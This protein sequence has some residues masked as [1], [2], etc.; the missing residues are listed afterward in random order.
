MF[1]WGFGPIVQDLPQ[2]AESRLKGR[3]LELSGGTAVKLLGTSETRQNL[4]LS[5]EW[6][7]P[8]RALQPNPSQFAAQATCYVRLLTSFAGDDT[9]DIGVL[10]IGARWSGI[11]GRLK[12]GYLE[13]GTGISLSDGLSIDVNDHFNFVSFLG[14]GAYFSESPNAPR[15][16]V[17]WSHISNAGLRPP[18][19]GLN[20]VEI[21]L[22]VRL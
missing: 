6:A 17:R 3:V 7:R 9:F 13:L 18:N 15:L 11:S 19:R 10:G 20:Q 2:A 22:G 21:V 14:G 8:S 4:S 12:N 1:V 5:L 16:G